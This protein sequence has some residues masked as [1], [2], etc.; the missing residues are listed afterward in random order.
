MQHQWDTVMVR[1]IGSD[2]ILY[3]YACFQNILR[4][5]LRIDTC[6]T[7]YQIWC[8]QQLDTLHIRHT[9]DRHYI[10]MACGCYVYHT[11]DSVWANGVFIDSIT[12]L[13][14]TVEN[15]EQDNLQLHLRPYYVH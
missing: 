7:D 12:I 9:N 6:Q 11:I 13:N 8:H 2:K 15:Y 10:S 5:P 3:N 14:N 4:L 1:G